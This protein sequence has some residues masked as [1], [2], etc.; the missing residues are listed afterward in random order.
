MFGEQIELDEL[1]Q[2]E[3][4]DVID[5]LVERVLSFLRKEPVDWEGF[6]TLNPVRVYDHDVDAYDH[7]WTHPLVLDLNEDAFILDTCF[8]DVYRHKNND[9]EGGHGVSWAGV[10][11]RGAV[12]VI[13]GRL[14][15]TRVWDLWPD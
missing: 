1:I 11:K 4:L 7:V 12:R 2:I 6:Q 9:P 13:E 10:F 5:R 3:N 14:G 8:L 15:N